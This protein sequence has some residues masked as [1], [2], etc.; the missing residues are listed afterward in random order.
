MYFLFS[1]CVSMCDCFLVIM[2]VLKAVLIFGAIHCNYKCG[3]VLKDGR[4]WIDN[5]FG[6]VT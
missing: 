6:D 2:I 4:F 3:S 1:I 5:L